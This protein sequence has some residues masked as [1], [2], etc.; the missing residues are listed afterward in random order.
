MVEVVEAFALYKLSDSEYKSGNC[1]TAF[2]L[3][4]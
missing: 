2:D 3:T 4:V 1:D